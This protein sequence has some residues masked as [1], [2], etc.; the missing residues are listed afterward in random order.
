MCAYTARAQRKHLATPHRYTL[1]DFG[2]STAQVD[3][4]LGSYA[5]D[6]DLI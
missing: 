4:R 2:L 3:E 1:A 5:E 6:F